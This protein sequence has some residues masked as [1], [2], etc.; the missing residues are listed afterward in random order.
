[1]ILSPNHS[2]T[3]VS[4]S[5][6]SCYGDTFGFFCQIPSLPF[7]DS[8]IQYI[9]VVWIIYP[10][11]AG[12]VFLLLSKV[13]QD[14][15]MFRPLDHFRLYWRTTG[16]SFFYHGTGHGTQHFW[17]CP[18]GVWWLLTASPQSS[19]LTKLQFLEKGKSIRN[20]GSLRILND[21]SSDKMFFPQ[22]F[23]M[24]IH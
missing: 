23:S 8:F 21:Y 9:D 12:P 4:L 17:R 16:R 20:S 11:L 14:V 18:P 19:H 10:L 15:A 7:L 1:M 5:T 3:C 13:M 6:A 22:K 2:K 24:V